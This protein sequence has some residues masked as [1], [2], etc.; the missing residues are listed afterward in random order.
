M[1]SL[2]TQ[3]NYTSDGFRDYTPS[4]PCGLFSLRFRHDEKVLTEGLL[5]NIHIPSMCI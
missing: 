3:R 2:P 4:E 1:V 5:I